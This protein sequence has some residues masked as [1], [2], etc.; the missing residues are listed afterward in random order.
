M[1]E[2]NINNINPGAPVA[3]NM[4]TSVPTTPPT[5]GGGT[6][7][8][9]NNQ[10]L[11]DKCGTYYPSS[12]RY[13]MKCGA[14]NYSHPDNQTMKQYINYDVV[15]HSYVE[16]FNSKLSHDSLDPTVRTKRNILIT[17]IILHLLVPGLLTGL[18]VAGVVAIPFIYLAIMFGIFGLVFVFNYSMCLLYDRAGEV[19][20]SHFVP[21]YGGVIYFKVS[22]F[23]AWYFLLAC[24]PVI[25][26]IVCLISLYKFGTRYGKNG[27]LTLLFSL[28]MIPY[29]AFSGASYSGSL[30][31]MHMNLG[32][33]EL[34]S[35]GRTKSERAYGA[36]KNFLI[37]VVFIALVVV[38]YLFHEILIEYGLKIWNFLI[39][40]YNEC[41]ELYNKYN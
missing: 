2:N 19:W 10:L 20:W 8:A 21:I 9:T 29:M 18:V 37:I 41:V 40:C 28:I 31:S 38:C 22:M 13:C 34:D 25:G 15:N 4:S 23:S 17:N 12:Q 27:W 6:S 7:S 24:V 11:C 1:N 36:K 26:L 14:L 35:K 5:V 30:K 39:Q 33:S 3:P 16:N 32:D